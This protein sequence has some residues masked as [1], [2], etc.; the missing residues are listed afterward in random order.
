MAWHQ[1]PIF[2]LRVVAA[3]VIAFYFPLGAVEA[4]ASISVIG[5][6]LMASGILPAMTLLVNAMKGE[7]RSPRNVRVL[8]EKLYKTLDNLVHAFI[9]A[10]LFIGFVLA[11]VVLGHV[12]ILHKDL[13]QRSLILCTVFLLLVFIHRSKIAFMTFFG[14]LYIRRDEALQLSEKETDKLGSQAKEDTRLPSDNY[15]AKA[16]PLHKIEAPS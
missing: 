5:V 3:A 7:E 6:G 4:C 9:R 8:Y 10:S 15:G 11:T 14:V 1:I 16:N 13:I 12:E 2:L